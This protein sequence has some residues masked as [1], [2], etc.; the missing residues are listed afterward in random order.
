MRRGEPNPFDPLCFIDLM[1]KARKIY[2]ALQ[3]L[4]IAVH[5]L[6]E[7]EDL[8][9]THLSQLLYLF[10]DFLTRAAPFPP[11]YIG[12]N[13]KGAEVIAPLHDRHIGFYLG[14]RSLGQRG[15]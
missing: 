4:S 8:S 2:L 12:D 7:K 3:P 9:H 6:T 14:Q 13:T 1:E 10:K 15:L 5:V 11:P